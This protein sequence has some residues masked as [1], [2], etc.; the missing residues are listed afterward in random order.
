MKIKSRIAFVFAAAVLGV[1]PLHAQQQEP[2]LHAQLIEGAR[3]LFNRLFR[4]AEPAAVAG[5]NS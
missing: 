3:G 5:K 1:Q 2:L 4:G